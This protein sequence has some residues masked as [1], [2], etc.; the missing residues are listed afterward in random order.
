M[1]GLQKC[2]QNNLISLIVFVLTLFRLSLN[3]WLLLKYTLQL[4]VRVLLKCH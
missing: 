4:Q 3:T 2:Y 1:K